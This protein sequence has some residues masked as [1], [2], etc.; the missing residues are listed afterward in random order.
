M[1][2]VEVTT[3]Q[4]KLHACHQVGAHGT[5]DAAIADL[6]EGFVVS[7]DEVAVD[8]DLPKLI[9]DDSDVGTRVVREDMIDERR[10][11]S[12]EKTRDDGHRYFL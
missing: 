4:E 8:P 9:D 1:I 10:L 12:A 6:N 3:F 2:Q 11:A 5:A 7:D